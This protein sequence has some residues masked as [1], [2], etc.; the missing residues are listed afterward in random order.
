MHT[1]LSPIFLASLSCI[2]YRPRAIHP[3]CCNFVYGHLYLYNICTTGEISDPGTGTARSGPGRGT[4]SNRGE[5]TAPEPFSRSRLIVDQT[6]ID[7]LKSFEARYHS[8]TWSNYSDCHRRHRPAR[9][10]TWS[11]R[12]QS[13]PTVAEADS[14]R[15][16]ALLAVRNPCPTPHFPGHRAK[17]PGAL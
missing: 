6:V 3:R 9:R 7:P 17:D 10:R 2:V 12:S 16:S 1:Y 15:T 11:A 8:T 13:E 4:T 5:S 14:R